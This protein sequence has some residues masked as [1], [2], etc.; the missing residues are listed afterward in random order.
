MR[1]FDDDTTAAKEQLLALIDA[2]FAALYDVAKSDVRRCGSDLAL[3][4]SH[5]FL[6]CHV[7]V[8]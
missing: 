3:P 7:T 4:A 2:D 1:A 6:P 8:L 5:I